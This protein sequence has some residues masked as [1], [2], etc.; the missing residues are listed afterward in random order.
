MPD[1]LAATVRL[2]TQLSDGFL[3]AAAPEAM[4]AYLAD[5]EKAKIRLDHRIEVL[6]KARDARQAEK[7]RGEWPANYVRPEEPDKQT[8]VPDLM[9]ALEASLA[10]AKEA[11]HNDLPQPHEPPSGTGREEV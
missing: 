9:A 11:A 8:R 3:A 7:D 6:R 4:S 2:R 1:R 10:R 5:W